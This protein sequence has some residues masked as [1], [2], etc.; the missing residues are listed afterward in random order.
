[1]V[2]L[3]DVCGSE[4]EGKV[5]GRAIRICPAAPPF[6]PPIV[7][8]PGS[9]ASHRRNIPFHHS[10]PPS[11]SPASQPH[12]HLRTSFTIPKM[13]T[14][15]P[16]PDPPKTPRAPVIPMSTRPTV[17]ETQKDGPHVNEYRAAEKQFETY[18]S[19]CPW[20]PS[21]LS[22]ASLPPPPSHHLSATITPGVV[23]GIV[24]A[25]VR[26]GYGFKVSQAVN[27]G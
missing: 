19:P 14:E 6:V 21:Q 25:F 18:V 13:A 2:E 12:S 10:R 11:S 5:W 9:S 1:M 7:R 4:A 20:I 27:R 17:S 3:I 24:F 23:M 16:T 15:T 22:P 26:A 8:L